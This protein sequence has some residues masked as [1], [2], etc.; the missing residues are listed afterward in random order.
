M[1][2]RCAWGTDCHDCGSRQAMNNSLTGEIELLRTARMEVRAAWTATQP[3][4]IMAYTDPTDEFGV[5]RSMESGRSIEPSFALHWHRM[6]AACCETG[7]LMLDVGSN[8]GYYALFAAA[9]GCRVVAWEPVP[10]FRAFLE[11]AVQLNHLS[12]RVHVR[13]AVVSD[14]PS[15]RIELAVPQRGIAGTA[16]LV[17]HWA[18]SGT[19]VD[20]AIGG[21]SIITARAETVD[22]A[23]DELGLLNE[24]PCAMKVDVEGHEPAVFAGAARLLARA[25]P[26]ALLFE[27]SPGVAE[28]AKVWKLLP[29]CAPMG[30]RTPLSTRALYACSRRA[31]FASRLPQ[32][33][34]HSSR[35]AERAIDCGT[36]AVSASRCDRPSRALST[37]AH[38]P[39]VSGAR[40]RCRRCARSVLVGWQR[41]CA[42][43]RIWSPT[44]G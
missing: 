30:T 32:T 14:R 31:A 44:S 9:M 26:R 22:D 27:Y 10:T 17:E 21:A 41:K 2:I 13:P 5:S 20:T 42:M 35:C 3:P 6:T 36:L 40:C 12:H 11:I 1:V 7:G 28:R 38:R 19:N 34:N 43:W 4:F 16:S 18:K 37:D 25:P 33:P 15:A 23:L 39:V 24:R 8:F 29:A